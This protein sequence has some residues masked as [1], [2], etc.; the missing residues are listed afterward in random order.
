VKSS[1]DQALRGAYASRQKQCERNLGKCVLHHILLVPPNFDRNPFERPA[2]LRIGM[3]P[4]VLPPATVLQRL[5]HSSVLKALSEDCL[6]YL[7]GQSHASDVATNVPRGL[8]ACRWTGECR[9]VRVIRQ[10]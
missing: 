9:F 3:S 2:Q 5:G 6:S 4:G 8:A 1:N 10:I 7:V